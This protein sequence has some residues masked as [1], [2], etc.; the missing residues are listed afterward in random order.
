MMTRRGMGSG[1]RRGLAALLGFCL[2][3]PLAVRAQYYEDRMEPDELGIR[4]I[5]KLRIPEAAYV[6]NDVCRQCHETAYQ[7]W[8]GT[9]HSRAFVPLYSMMAMMMGEE[10]GATADMAIRS[11]KCLRCHALAHDVP[12]AYRGPGFRLG[13]GVTCERCHGP[14]GDHV[15]AF[16]DPDSGADPIL[17][18]PGEEFCRGCHREK[19]GHEGIESKLANFAKA[20]KRIAHPMEAERPEDQLEPGELGIW[21]VEETGTP[22]ASYVG[23]AACGGCHETAFERW[24]QSAHSG[25]FY[26]MR[27]EMAYM[28]D[29]QQGVTVGGPAKNGM[30]LHCHATGSEAP[31]AYRESGFRMREGVGCEKCHGPGGDHVRAVRDDDA[32]DDTGLVQAPSEVPCKTCHK[33]KKSHAKL[34]TER[35]SPAV[36]WEAIAH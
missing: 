9:A 26:A 1:H 18:A 19:M 29:M 20:R 2:M 4:D 35:F 34:R 10:M 8:L 15:R 25:A 32:V 30:C 33:R 36:A 11:G 17:G 24:Q 28:M 12:A 27:S 31:A 7:T 22:K 23:S 3:V 13:E 21:H 6:G 16:E 14:G 5:E